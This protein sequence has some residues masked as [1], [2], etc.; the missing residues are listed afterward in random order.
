MM[1]S[2]QS[3]YPN[4]RTEQQTPLKTYLLHP[5]NAGTNNV[6]IY[7]SSYPIVVITH[8]HY[9]H[10]PWENEANE[11]GSCRHFAPDLLVLLWAELTYPFQNPFAKQARFC[12]QGKSSYCNT[13]G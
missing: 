4:P 12:F 2:E 5:P 8:A 13:T 1:G 11:V 3:P 6:Y 9:K 10:L 7:F